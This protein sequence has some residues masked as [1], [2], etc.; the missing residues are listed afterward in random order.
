MRSSLY[1]LAFAAL[2]VGCSVDE[3]GKIPCDNSDNCPGEFGT[4]STGGFCVVSTPPTVLEV[5]SPPAQTG[6]VNTTL[7]APFTVL[8]KDSNGNPAPKVAVT[9]AV[10]SGGGSVSAVSANTGP[11]GKA[12]V[13]AKLGTQAGANSFTA[14]VAGVAT[15][16]T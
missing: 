14:T 4:C 15:P 9:F 5:Q 8:V 11:D 13:S 3:A 12:S 10:A 7:A 6:V 16:A 1:A 2:A